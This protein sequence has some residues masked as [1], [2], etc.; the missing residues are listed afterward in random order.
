MFNPTDMDFWF[1][2]KDF[3]TDWTSGNFPNWCRVFTERRETVTRILEI[4][5]WEGRSAIFFLEFF[6]HASVT[7]IDAFAGGG[8]STNPALNL[9]EARFDKNT[10]QYGTRVTKIAAESVVALHGLIKAG[11]TYD[12]IYVDGS[13]VRDDVTIDSL[14]V[15]R[16]TA[17]GTAII[18]DDYEGGRPDQPYETRVKAAI[19]YFLSLYG[20]QLSILHRGYQIIAQ[21]IA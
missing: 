4:G 9:A 1:A 15:W 5:A 18:W 13:H 12:L 14:M 20:K 11:K 2:G 7:C 21:R 8:T 6:P 19:D 17:P 3:S 16:L 10:K